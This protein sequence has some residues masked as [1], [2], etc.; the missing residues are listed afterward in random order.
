MDE[1]IISIL[2]MDARRT[3][4]DIARELGTSEGTVRARIKKLI[5][6]GQ[7]RKFTIKTKSRNITAF[8]DVKVDTNSLTRDISLAI[9]DI[10]GV[11]S[12]YEISG[13]YDIVVLVDVENTDRLNYIIDSIRKLG[14]EGTRTRMILVEH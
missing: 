11:E 13:D 5:S 6:S 7:I 10:P 2:K 8:I 12:V 14:V 3:N 4:V 1:K 9:K